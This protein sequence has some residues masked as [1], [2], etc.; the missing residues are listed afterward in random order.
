MHNLD[1]ID[2]AKGSP[3]PELLPLDL[4]TASFDALRCSGVSPSSILDYGPGAGDT[5]VRQVIAEWLSRRYMLPQPD[6]ARVSVTGGA[7]Q[8]IACILQ[9]FTSLDYT[10]TIYIVAPTY[11]LV[12]DIFE[13]HG[14]TGR[15][16]AIPEDEQGLDIEFLEDKMGADSS[17]YAKDE[18]KVPE[19]RN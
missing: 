14:F 19:R 12:C 3:A 6:T 17:L 9:C 10:Q 1:T 15:L 16:R 2:L 5:H 4:L 13:D 7:S 18:V 8:N 11:H